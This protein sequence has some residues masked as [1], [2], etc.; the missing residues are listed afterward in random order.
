[1]LGRNAVVTGSTSGIG[2]AIA[3][4]LAGEGCNVMLNGFG[5]PREIE[6]VRAAIAAATGRTVVYCDADLRH[7]AQARTLIEKAGD[8]FGSLDIVV[9]NAGVQHVAPLS[10][11]PDE[12]WDLILAVN[13]SAAFHTTKAAV[14]GMVERGFGRIVN[15]ASA[16]GL[17]GA[18]H[19]PAYVASKHGLVGLTKAVAL[20]IAETGVTCNVVC[21]GMVMTPT[22]RC[23]SP[24]KP[25]Q[26]VWRPR[27]WSGTSF[28]KTSPL[29][30]LSNPKR[31]Q[32]PSSSYVPRR[33]RA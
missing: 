9:N 31:S 12:K 28:C 6:A 8:A 21:P 2:L 13:L 11:F 1:L 30:G 10:E 24:G 23:R 15:I 4:A 26:Q 18:P 25:T 17:V 3:S 33:P 32:P 14:P 16:L 7:P 29:G 19:K 20:E 27:T 22:S 5:E